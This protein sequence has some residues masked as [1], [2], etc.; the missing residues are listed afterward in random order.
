MAK[1][2]PIE[3]LE[4]THQFPG[5]YTFKAIG[6]SEADFV[7]RVVAVI[8]EMRQLTE[9]PPYVARSTSGGKHVSVTLDIPVKDAADVH[10]IYERLMSVPGL[11]VL[12]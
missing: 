9:D 7:T 4:A 6:T 10:A 2:P 12:L 3:L 8:R 11:I 5:V 1:L